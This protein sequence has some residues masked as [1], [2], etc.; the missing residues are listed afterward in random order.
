MSS[1]QRNLEKIAPRRALRA[2]TLLLKLKTF[3]KIN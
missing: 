1:S 3:I 2:Q